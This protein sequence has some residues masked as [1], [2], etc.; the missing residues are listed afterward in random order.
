MVTLQ[1]YVSGTRR[2]R[3]PHAL[4]RLNARKEATASERVEQRRT[5]HFLYAIVRKVT[6][7][8]L[9]SE[10]QLLRIYVQG[11]GDIF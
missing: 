7:E 6:N 5:V 4:H 9:P 11:D 8:L 2:G 10:K 1:D 3:P